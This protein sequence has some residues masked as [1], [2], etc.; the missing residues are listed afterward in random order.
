MLNPIGNCLAQS[1]T[2]APTG[3]RDRE[4]APTKAGGQGICYRA[5]NSIAFTIRSLD[6]V[7]TKIKLQH[8][9]PTFQ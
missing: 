7:G 9:E 2:Y 5:E 3:N 6:G 1:G 8:G 4:V